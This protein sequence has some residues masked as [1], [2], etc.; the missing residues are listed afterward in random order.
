MSDHIGVVYIL[1]NPS[2]PEY[3]K[4]GYAD[5]VNKRLS[6]LNSSEC[7]PFAFRLYAFYEVNERLKDLQIHDMID[8]INPELRSIDTF[9]GKPRK[10]EFYKMCKEDAYNILDCIATLSGTN[11]RLHLNEN[12][13]NTIDKDEAAEIDTTIYKIETYLKNKNQ[14]IIN[15][16][17]LICKSIHEKL[18]DT[19]TQATPN[20]IALRNSNGQNICEF[21]LYKSRILI[22]TKTPNEPSLYN[23][24]KVPDKYLWALNYRISINTKE[25]VIKIINLLIDAYNQIK[26]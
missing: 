21:H 17:R 11:N 3:V 4:I 20:Y 8:K 26:K 18:P 22:I 16:Y 6:S 5:D 10:R 9:N 13:D 25:E 23:G 2:F 1:T 12:S 7:I 24:E 15:L 14:D 19:Y